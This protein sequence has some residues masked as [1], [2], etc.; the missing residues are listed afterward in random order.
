M[1][2]LY[3]IDALGYIFR[4]YYALPPMTNKEGKLTN[5]LY[6]F[7]LQLKKILKTFSPEHIAIVFDGPSHIESRKNIYSEYKSNRAKAEE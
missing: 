4:A 6:G 7:A 3:L 5:A 1:K 2:S